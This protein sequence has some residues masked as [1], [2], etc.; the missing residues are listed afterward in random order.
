MSTIPSA[1][2]NHIMKEIVTDYLGYHIETES[3][4]GFTFR[5]NAGDSFY[6]FFDEDTIDYRVPRQPSGY[7]EGSYNLNNFN[8]NDAME[9]FGAILG[10]NIADIVHQNDLQADVNLN[11]V[12]NNQQQEL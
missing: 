6:M 8:L 5:N 10:I 3:M 12:N 1:F 9:L 7:A 2:V 11:I 4:E